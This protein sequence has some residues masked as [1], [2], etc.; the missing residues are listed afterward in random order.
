MAHVRV[1][2]HI[3]PPF[4]QVAIPIFHLTLTVKVPTCKPYTNGPTLQN[5]M[6]N[7]HVGADCDPPHAFLDAQGKGRS[8]CPQGKVPRRGF[9][10]CKSYELQME[11]KA[12]GRWDDTCLLSLLIA[13]SS[14][15]PAVIPRELRCAQRICSGVTRPRTYLVSMCRICQCTARR[16]FRHRSSPEQTLVAQ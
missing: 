8:S 15:W 12:H 6:A 11:K 4:L 14:L 3:S 16:Q 9:E 5:F 2:L 7:I 13:A 10:L 1:N